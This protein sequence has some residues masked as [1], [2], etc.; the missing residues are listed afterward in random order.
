[1]NKTAMDL[2]KEAKAEIREMDLRQAHDKHQTEAVVII[3][4]REAHEFSA[5]HIPGAHHISR[6]ML[7][8][9]ADSHPALKDKDREI[10]VYC[11]TGG[12]AALA[13]HQLKKMG[14][15][16]VHSI[17]GGMD[18]WNDADHPVHKP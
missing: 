3:D 11:K 8:F 18:A 15:T 14:Y 4:V 9:K 16:N 17:S 1:M 12:R 5:G 6:G 7:E 10:L 2:V 13:A